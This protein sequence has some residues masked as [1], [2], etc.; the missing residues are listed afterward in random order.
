[1]E[2]AK[3]ISGVILAGGE[4]KRFGGINKSNIIVGGLSVI[5]RII[6]TISDIFEEIIIVSNK[7]DEFQSFSNFKI[8]TD[9]FLKVGPLG[10][11]HAAMKASSNVSIFVF[12]GDM[13][14]VDKEVILD[15][16]SHFTLSHPEAIIPCV[17]GFIEPLHAIYNNSIY[18]KLDE[19]L[20][21]KN[22]YAIRD[23]LSNVDVDYLNLPST[24]QIKKAFTNINTPFSAEE[25]NRL[26]GI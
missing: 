4:S 7:P 2:K 21:G 13:P 25:A 16:I 5:S 1:M 24:E 10:G 19:Y 17:G 15:Q 3:D 6:D 23:F 8:V 12:A 9:Q 26:A 11:I 22:R 20:S 18:N 14:F